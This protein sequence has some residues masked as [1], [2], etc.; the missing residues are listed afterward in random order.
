VKLSKP[1]QMIVGTPSTIR[2]ITPALS[3]LAR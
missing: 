1:I 2:D 3:D